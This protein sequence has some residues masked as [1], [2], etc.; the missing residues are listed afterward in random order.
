MLADTSIQN[1]S[2]LV[3]VWSRKISLGS[4]PDRNKYGALMNFGMEVKA[5]LERPQADH[6]SS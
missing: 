3:S 2:S 4:L 1:V 6:R 5:A